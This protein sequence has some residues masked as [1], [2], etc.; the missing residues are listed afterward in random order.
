MDK[1]EF[2]FTCN[3][4]SR[5][6]MMYLISNLAITYQGLSGFVLFGGCLFEI[7]FLPIALAIPE[8]IL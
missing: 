5:S 6:L 1:A 8:L 2:D 4:A 3:M 7:G